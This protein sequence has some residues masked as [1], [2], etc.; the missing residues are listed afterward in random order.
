MRSSLLPSAPSVPPPSES[1]AFSTHDWEAHEHRSFAGS[2]WR[3]IRYCPSC[4]GSERAHSLSAL[5]VL[6]VGQ[7][8][9]VEQREALD[10]VKRR[11]I[12]NA[13]ATPKT[14]LDGDTSAVCMWDCYRRMTMLEPLA[15]DV[16]Q[17]G[18]PGDFLEAGVFRGGISIHLAAILALS[19]A[20]GNGPSQRRMW[21]ADSF[22]GMPDRS[23]YG[24]QWVKR[25]R[26]AGQS[27]LKDLGAAYPPLAVELTRTERA[28][29]LMALDRDARGLTLGQFNTTLSAVR[30]NVRR[31]LAGVLRSSPRSGCDLSAGDALAAC[32]VHFVRGFFSAS[33][34]GPVKR[35][36]LLRIDADLYTS[37]I[38]CLEA[39]YPLLSPGGYVV[40]DD[41]KI[42]QVRTRQRGRT[43]SP[44]RVLIS[45]CP[46]MPQARAAIL[47]FRAQRNIT[48][49]VR[50]SNRY[51]T[52]VAS[53]AHAAQLAP[54]HT[55]DRIAFW[56]KDSVLHA[57]S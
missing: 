51:D 26:A 9:S 40:F 49:P 44:M 29:T 28:E 6:S 36:A 24:E 25:Q 54:F 2:T 12:G 30:E 19:G 4:D 14:N 34:P 33:L 20:L 56:R 5:R 3:Q 48:A 7:L 13:S 27:N 32:G 47:D 10:A 37:V 50:T 38:E 55:L 42:N 57:F 22:E 31:H 18:V 52:R 45:H 21:L 23:L 46:T 39:L 15:S 17:K 43:L 16:L 11:L 53:A 41:F 35:L 8:W 1:R